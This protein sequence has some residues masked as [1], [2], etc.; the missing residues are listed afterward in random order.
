[1]GC[2]HAPDETLAAQAGAVVRTVHGAS[3]RDADAPAAI[4]E[5]A[6]ARRIWGE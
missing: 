3:H 6:R 5:F 4:L 1:M 2:P